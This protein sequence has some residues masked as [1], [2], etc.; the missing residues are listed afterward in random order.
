MSCLRVR[1]I[2]VQMPRAGET[3]RWNHLFLHST[4]VYKHH[5]YKSDNIGIKFEEF[6]M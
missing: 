1:S 2:S 5:T 3:A 6:Q 4:V